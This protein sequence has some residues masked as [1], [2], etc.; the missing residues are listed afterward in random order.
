[1]VPSVEWTPAMSGEKHALSTVF[2]CTISH[3]SSFPP[4]TLIPPYCVQGEGALP[5]PDSNSSVLVSKALAGGNISTLVWAAM[6]TL[7]MQ[8]H[9]VPGRGGTIFYPHPEHLV[10]WSWPVS[11]II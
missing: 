1:M 4:L 7:T 3:P 5:H 9:A 2:S 8:G 11:S 6:A 10:L